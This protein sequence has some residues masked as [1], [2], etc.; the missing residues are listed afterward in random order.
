M[1]SIGI[2]LPIA[3]AILLAVG[4]YSGRR[5]RIKS[6]NVYAHNGAIRYTRI[7]KRSTTS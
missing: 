1:E 5:T 6:T 4:A 3:L 7:A 2:V